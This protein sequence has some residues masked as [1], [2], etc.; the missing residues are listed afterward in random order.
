MGVGRLAKIFTSR[1][2]CSGPGGQRRPSSEGPS[3]QNQTVPIQTMSLELK[4]TAGCDPGLNETP[5][6]DHPVCPRPEQALWMWEA[7]KRQRNWCLCGGCRLRGRRDKLKAFQA[8]WI[9][10]YL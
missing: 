7:R 8:L 9:L 4:T 1:I 6:P 2:I 3:A 10:F 5:H